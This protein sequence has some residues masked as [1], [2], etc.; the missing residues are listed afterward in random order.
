MKTLLY[1]CGLTLLVG[2]SACAD[3]DILEAKPG[4]SLPPVSNLAMEKTGA[5]DL[6][7]T[8]GIPAN[9]PGE[10][11]Q[12]VSVFIQ[13]TEILSP[14]TAVPVFSITIP[15][16][17]GEFSYEVPDPGKTYHLTVKLYGNT[18]V[19]DKNYSSEIYSEG[20]TV[21]YSP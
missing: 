11:N 17:P 12:P 16:A 2:T 20:Q 14:T 5:K 18:K 19:T 21:V 1:I 9:L 6:N 15:D 8:W 7:L 4:V 13:V 3:R 10:I